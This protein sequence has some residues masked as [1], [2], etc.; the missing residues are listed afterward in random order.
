MHSGEKESTEKTHP[1]GHEPKIHQ[2]DPVLLRAL[3]GTRHTKIAN[4]E[5]VTC[6]RCLA[7]KEIRYRGYKASKDA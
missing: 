3:C 4:W 2:A 5:D 6:L 1:S 7:Q